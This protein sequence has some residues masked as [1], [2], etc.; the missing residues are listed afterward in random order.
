MVAVSAAAGLGVAVFVVVGDAD[1][2]DASLGSAL[3]LGDSCNG[4]AEAAPTSSPPG[5]TTVE[6]VDIVLV[7]SAFTATTVN[8]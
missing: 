2:D 4:V 5:V 3:A 8:V 7:P 1:S 6:A